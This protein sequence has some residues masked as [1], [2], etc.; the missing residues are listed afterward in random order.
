MKKD[1]FVYTEDIIEA[2]VKIERYLGDK[3]FDDFES[4]DVIQDA[5][6]RNL[7]IIGET[8]AKLLSSESDLPDELISELR[9]A[10][11]MRNI[12]IHN[13]DS[14]NIDQ[15]WDTTQVN[16]PHLKQLLDSIRPS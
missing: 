5:V 4:D 8:A 13:Y 7:E 6:I 3:I 1:K 14:V 16:L 10:K 15:V 11:G 12:L 2:I 9:S